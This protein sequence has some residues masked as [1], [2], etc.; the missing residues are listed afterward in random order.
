MDPRWPGSGSGEREEKRRER[1]TRRLSQ[2]EHQLQGTG[3]QGERERVLNGRAFKYGR[4]HSP[5][6]VLSRL[7]TR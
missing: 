5:L 2:S 6:T 4:G 1:T 3:E 7:P